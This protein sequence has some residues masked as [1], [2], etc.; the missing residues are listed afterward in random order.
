MTFSL[1]YAIIYIQSKEYIYDEDYEHTVTVFEKSTF[2]KTL[3]QNDKL[4]DYDER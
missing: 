1:V 4:H 2:E 3:P